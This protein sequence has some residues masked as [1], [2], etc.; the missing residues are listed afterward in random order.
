[1]VDHWRVEAAADQLCRYGGQPFYKEFY[2]VLEALV[3]MNDDL[4]HMR[5]VELIDEKARVAKNAIHAIMSKAIRGAP[6][7]SGD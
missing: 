1:M 2:T 4:H 3:D 7:E 6:V 5:S